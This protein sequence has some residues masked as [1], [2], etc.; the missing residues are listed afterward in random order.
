MKNCK[1]NTSV[2]Y[3]KPGYEDN[4]LFQADD[5]ENFLLNDNLFSSAYITKNRSFLTWLDFTGQPF[6]LE[7]MSKYIEHRD[8]LKQ[9]VSPATV[10]TRKYHMKKI[11]QELI[12]MNP[13]R[14]TLLE[15]F[16]LDAFFSNIRP[17]SL[18]KQAI[19]ESKILTEAEV[20]RL[21]KNAGKEWRL[22]LLFLATTGVRVSE[23]VSI[24]RPRCA[25]TRK[26]VRITIVGKGGKQ[27]IIICDK[28]LFD[29]IAEEFNSSYFLFCTSFGTPFQSKSYL[30]RVSADR[31]RYPR[32]AYRS[33]HFQT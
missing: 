3:T 23:L 9:Y 31:D 32:E 22:I 26:D 28:Q 5:L 29:A 20:S 4:A 10:K 12:R 14:W 17:G 19:P 21:L 30:A 16:R 1:Q 13:D 11:C 24:I 27:R 6:T 7:S 2:V 18:Q 15:Q 25:V 8:L 33:T